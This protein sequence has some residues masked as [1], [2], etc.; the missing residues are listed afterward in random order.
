MVIFK[1]NLTRSRRR[2][3]ADRKSAAESA[4]LRRRLQRGVLEVDMTIALAILFIAVLPLAYSFASDAKAMRRNYERA[5]AMEL[6]DGKMEVL[7]AGAWRNHPAGTNEIRLAGHAAAN[8]S[9]DRALLIIQP[10]RIRLEWRPANRYSAV[11]IRE[12]KLP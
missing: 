8:L 1:T 6:L 5:V 4:S 9:T 3:E 10:D 12:M 2:E 11:I 7:A